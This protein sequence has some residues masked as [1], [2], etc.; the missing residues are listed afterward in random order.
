MSLEIELQ[1]FSVNDRL[2]KSKNTLQIGCLVESRCFN[3][4][5]STLMLNPILFASQKLIRP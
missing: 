3:L 5:K 2:D 4:L 1:A